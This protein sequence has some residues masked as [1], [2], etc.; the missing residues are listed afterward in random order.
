MN[1]LRKRLLLNLTLLVVV[2]GLIALVLHEQRDGEAP[3]D[4]R[5]LGLEQ[6]AIEQLR[7]ERPE[8]P[9]VHVVRDAD[10]QWQLREPLA[11]AAN[12]QRIDSLLRVARLQ[13]L[14]SFPL[15]GE[16]LSDYGLQ[17]PVV[18]LVVNDTLRLDFGGHTA[19]DYRRYL[20][21]GETIHIVP[22]TLYYHLIG[23]P[24]GFVAHRLLPEGA[25]INALELP[26]R[27]LY[28]HDGQWRLE[29]EDALRSAD[30][31][32]RL[33][34]AWQ[35]P[36]IIQVRRYQGQEGSPIRVHLEDGRELA[37]LLLREEEIALAR[38]DLGIQYQLSA[39]G[40]RELLGLQTQ[41]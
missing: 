2:V 7:I 24:H 41:E 26:E 34:D 6:E 40:A 37:F 16:T 12:R 20:R 14:G 8:Q 36:G 22:D 38:P 23:E 25:R 32:Q 1:T 29:P 5:L 18:T 31:I 9:A 4:H 21:L 13:S 11:I 35:H 15:A 39:S 27:Q 28:R 3:E 33:L 30:D 17:T 10:G 19:L